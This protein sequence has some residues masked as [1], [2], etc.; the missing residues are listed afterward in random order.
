M[1]VPLSLPQDSSLYLDY[2]SF[3]YFVTANSICI[4]AGAD[5]KYDHF[6]G[7][8][9]IVYG[10]LVKNDYCGYVIEVKNMGYPISR[11]K[12]I[13]EKERVP[14]TTSKNISR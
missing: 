13:N 5:K 12:E 3:K 9:V 11:E 8:A 2:W 10:T 7:S 1:D 6:H 4:D 14:Q